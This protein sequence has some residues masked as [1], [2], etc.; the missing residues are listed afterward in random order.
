MEAMSVIDVTHFSD[1]ACPWAYSA[2]PALAVLRWRYGSQLR[3]RH[4]MIGLTERAEQ[5]EARGYTPVRQARGYRNFRWR[6]MPFSTA[7]KPRLAGTA[8]A[9][10]A[11]VATRIVQPELE[12]AAFRALQFGQFTSGRPMDD[13]GAIH[14]A[15]TRVDDLDVQRIVSLIDTP[16]VIDAYEADRAEARTAEGGPTEFQ[17]RSANS[18]GKVRFTAPSLVFTQGDRRLEAGGF[19]PLEAYDVCIANLDTSLDRREPPEDI[20][21][22]LA[23]EPHGLTTR[24]VAAVLAPRLDPPDD[25]AAEDAL[26]GLLAEGRARR[27]DL[28]NDALW[29]PAA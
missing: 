15:L 16:E 20:A 6:G 24:E 25:A 3:W 11:V 27:E 4:V 26:I 10:R 23:T 1:P 9:C 12:L 29:R 7:V 17:G 8:R 14:D 13:D 2:S 21:E 5:Y 28:G 19:Q 18:D 22:L